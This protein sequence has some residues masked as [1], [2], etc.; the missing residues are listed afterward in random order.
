MP[1]PVSIALVGI[2]GYG[3][4]YVRALLADGERHGV[5]LVGVVDPMPERCPLLAELQATGAPFYADLASFYA[6]NGADLAVIS[7]PIHFHAAQSCLALGSGSHVLCEKPAAATIQDGLTMAATARESGRFLAIGYQW[8]YSDAMRAV[9]RDIQAGRFG[10]P[11]RLRSYVLWPRRA[12]YYARNRWAGRIRSDE[13]DWVL[14]SPVNNAAAHYLHNMFYV[15]GST[16][17]SSARPVSVQAQLMRANPIENYDTAALRCLT[18][19]GVEILFYTSHAVPHNDGPVFAY[20]FEEATVHYATGSGGE[21]GVPVVARYPN[22]R[23]HVY[24]DPFARDGAKLWQA[25]DAVRSGEPVDCPI[26]AAL[27]HLAVVNAIQNAVSIQNAP[28]DRMQEENGL[29]WVTGLEEALLASYEAGSLPG[30]RL[31]SPWF[32]SDRRT[33][34]VDSK[35]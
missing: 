28:M 12:D 35:W 25:V 1:S 10:R 30:E 6:E 3:A 5:R 2:G 11:L 15:L 34:P 4:L 17:Q 16:R 23:S 21:R 22:G 14:D 13:G 29:R 24:T 19:E 18:E 7:S 31:D 9:K 20:E 27:P 26:E 33:I 8:S 32:T